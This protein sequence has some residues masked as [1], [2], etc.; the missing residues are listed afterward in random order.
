MLDYKGHPDLRSWDLG[1]LFDQM[2][3]ESKG[4]NAEK[5]REVWVSCLQLLP[6]SSREGK[7]QREQ[8]VR[9]GGSCTRCLSPPG[10]GCWG[11]CDLQHSGAP[12]R[13][14]GELQKVH[15][16]VAPQGDSKAE[17]IPSEW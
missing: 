9:G 14:L 16:K 8:K 3:Q 15:P 11:F 4:G 7:G 12:Q 6:S 1:S 13:A 10:H 17:K 5:I 2:H